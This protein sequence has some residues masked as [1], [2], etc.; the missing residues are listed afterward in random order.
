MNSGLASQYIAAVALAGRVPCYVI[1]PVRRGQMMVSA[2]NGRARAEL[3]PEMGTVIGKAL[4]DFNGESG[5]IEIVV[6]RI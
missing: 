6:G 4:E 1:G 5:V 3:H 2:G